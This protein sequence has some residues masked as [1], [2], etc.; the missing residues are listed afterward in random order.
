VLELIGFQNGRR[1][2]VFQLDPCAF[3]KSEVSA[4]MLDHTDLLQSAMPSVVPKE[5]LLSVINCIRFVTGVVIPFILAW[6]NNRVGRM[7]LPVGDTV[8]GA[9]KTDLRMI[10][11]A[12]AD[13]KHDIPAVLA[14]D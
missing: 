7:P 1:R 6:T 3:G 2:P 5:P 11:V 9:G 13:I 14:H 4:P 8:A 10:D 12:K